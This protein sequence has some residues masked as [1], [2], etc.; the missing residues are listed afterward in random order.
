M[1]TVIQPKTSAAVSAPQRGGLR[2]FFSFPDPV[3]EVSARLVAAG[4]LLMGVVALIFD[5]RVT[6]LLAVLAYGFIARV[7]TGP[8][9]SPLG[10]LV[11]R[12]VTPRLPVAEKPVPGPPKRFAQGMGVVFTVTALVLTLVGEHL[13]ARVVLGLLV[14]AAML[15]SVFAL[16]LG[17]KVFA[18]L[19]RLGIVPE[20]VCERCNN[21]SLAAR[22]YCGF[23]GL[24]RPARS[25]EHLSERG[26]HRMAL[27]GTP[28]LAVCKRLARVPTR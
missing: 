6:W 3:N 27:G 11:T 2:T 16:C 4:V 9:M 8:T 10:Q 21:L 19:M 22:R 26:R 14:V 18:L 5:E 28:G 12:V 23:R 25:P 17:C 13:A 7:L 15:E 1:T 24:P 20:Q